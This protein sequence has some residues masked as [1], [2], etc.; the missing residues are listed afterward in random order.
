MPRKITSREV[1]AFLAEKLETKGRAILPGLGTLRLV[2]RAGRKIVHPTSRL[3]YL[4]PPR[5]RLFSA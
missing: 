5:R 4:I 2:E 1:A 3:V